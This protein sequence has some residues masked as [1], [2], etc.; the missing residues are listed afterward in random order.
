MQ[1]YTNRN[2]NPL[3]AI[4]EIKGN[5]KYPNIK[6]SVIF[7]KKNDGV[8]VTAEI[9]GLP[10]SDEKCTSEIFAFHIHNGTSCTGNYIDNFANAGTHFNPNNCKHPAH[11]GDLPP[12]FSNNGYAYL[13]VYTNKFTINDIIGKVIIIHD[14]PDDFITQPSG[15]SGNKI[16]CG[17]ILVF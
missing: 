2:S 14:K 13:S 10:Y 15:N 3:I 6:G 8:I 11:A 1:N 16:A 9:F 7:K 12:L 5:N 17:K 4:A